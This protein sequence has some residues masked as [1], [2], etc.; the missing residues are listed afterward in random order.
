MS[1]KLYSDNF[2]V[3]KVKIFI[4][5]LCLVQPVVNLRRGGVG[6]TKTDKRIYFGAGG[7]LHL[8]EDTVIPPV[9]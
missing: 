1:T 5:E 2:W 9:S 4:S 8:D 6:L 3:G 7:S